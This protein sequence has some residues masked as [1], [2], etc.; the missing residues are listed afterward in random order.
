MISSESQTL[1]DTI[2]SYQ[3]LNDKLIF[4]KNNDCYFYG[5]SVLNVLLVTTS[6]L[7]KFSG[8]D[9]TLYLH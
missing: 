2:N 7:F 9:L 4:V 6:T 1:I 5:F 3:S 8:S